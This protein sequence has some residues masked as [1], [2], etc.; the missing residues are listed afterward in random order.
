MTSFDNFTE[1]DYRE[2]AMKIV[3]NLPKD[4]KK[5]LSFREL[6][7]GKKFMTK[8]GVKVRSKNEKI[9]ADFYFDQGISVEY[10]KEVLFPKLGNPKEKYKILCDFY[11]SDYGIFHEHF[12][13]EDENYKRRKDFKKSAFQRFKM[14]FMYTDIKDETNLEVSIKEKLKNLGLSFE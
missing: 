6:E 2:M 5:M 13:L 14:K 12:G 1:K 9:I 7:K 10:E 3:E 11:L 8:S 4:N